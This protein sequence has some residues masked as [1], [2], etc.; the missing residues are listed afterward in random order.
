MKVPPGHLCRGKP[1]YQ[2]VLKFSPR[3]FIIG[4]CPN[5]K[6]SFFYTMAAMQFIGSLSEIAI[7]VLVWI[8]MGINGVDIRATWMILMYSACSLLSPFT[9]LILLVFRFKPIIIILAVI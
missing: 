6:G 8:L 1:K 3:D 9:G 2:A 4:M 7:A 5:K